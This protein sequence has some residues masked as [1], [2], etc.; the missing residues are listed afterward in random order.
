[1]NGSTYTGEFVDDVLQDRDKWKYPYAG[2]KESIESLTTLQSHASVHQQPTP[3]SGRIAKALEA[4]TTAAQKDVG[5]F[6]LLELDEL[7]R[8]HGQAVLKIGPNH[9][10]LDGFVQ[11]QKDALTNILL[12][13]NTELLDIYRF[14]ASLEIDISQPDYK[15]PVLPYTP[16]SSTDPLVRAP[17]SANPANV[18]TRL[19]LGQLWA[20]IQ[21][22]GVLGTPHA[23]TLTLADINRLALAH[24]SPHNYTLVTGVTSKHDPRQILLL[25]EFAA[26]LIRIAEVMYENSEEELI[27]YYS[28]T[29]ALNLKVDEES[30][31]ESAYQPMDVNDETRA[32]SDGE[33]SSVQ[34]EDAFLLYSHALE[35]FNAYITGADPSPQP[36]FTQS[37]SAHVHPAT[38][39]LAAELQLSLP[40]LNTNTPASATQPHQASSPTAS[41]TSISSTKPSRSHSRQPSDTSTLGVGAFTSGR[42]HKTDGLASSRS[43]RNEFS[44]T[45]RSRGEMLASARSQKDANLIIPQGGKSQPFS[46]TTSITHNTN[47]HP[48][49]K[50]FTTTLT[51]QHGMNTLAQRFKRFLLEFILPK[52][53][54]RSK[55]GFT[56]GG[57]WGVSAKE[58]ISR[59]TPIFRSQHIKQIFK[60]YEAELYAKVYQPNTSE[61]ARDT[62][63]ATTTNKN[64]PHLLDRTIRLVDVLA[65]LRNQSSCFNTYF[66]LYHALDALFGPSSQF[67]PAASL[68]AALQRELLWEEFMDLLSRI[69]IARGKVLAEV[70]ASLERE[71]AARAAIDQRRREDELAAQIAAEAAVAAA[72]AEQPLS[73]GEPIGDRPRSKTPAGGPKSGS[74]KKSASASTS[75]KSSTAK[76]KTVPPSPKSTNKKDGSNKKSTVTGVSGTTPLPVTPAS[77]SSS[78]P[79]AAPSGLTVPSGP[80]SVTLPSSPQTSAPSSG[81]H[82]SHVSLGGESG[83]FKKRSNVDAVT[84]EMDSTLVTE[85]TSPQHHQQSNMFALA[86]LES[87]YEKYASDTEHLICSLLQKDS[88]GLL[89]SFPSTLISNI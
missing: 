23:P 12:R 3:A 82:H 13:Y 32:D 77:V 52:A 39:P 21:D 6:D 11:Q 22:T 66:T 16:H 58:L 79:A 8:Q 76:S 51:S 20:L 4:A 42:S 19:C 43:Q 83:S 88:S 87:E 10:A 89:T 49:N 62:I 67:A 61:A 36:P 72:T 71:R 64:G 54:T 86:A 38:S 57:A 50:S 18:S 27:P 84:N 2:V 40:P 60:R 29:S 75:S 41:S 28:H 78:N 59:Q 70:A 5:M 15:P 46:S 30:K 47:R 63:V 74:S 69:G 55:H 1:M 48:S 56:H 34:D 24:V 25:R 53:R 7:L 45:G 9:P 26:G 44:V 17:L 65:H 85:L 68:Q 37:S 81:R 73:D 31:T 33:P 80:S 35:N 14:Y